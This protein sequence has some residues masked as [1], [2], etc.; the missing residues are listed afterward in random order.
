MVAGVITMV[1]VTVITMVGAEAITMDGA[2]ITIGEN[3]HCREAA[4]IFLTADDTPALSI[5]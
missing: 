2:I 3:I 4:T 5:V 1:G